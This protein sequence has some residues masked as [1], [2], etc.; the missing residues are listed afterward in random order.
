MV[1]S[2]I[3]ANAALNS[4]ENVSKNEISSTFN[5]AIEQ[6]DIGSDYIEII[7]LTTSNTT[8]KI[9]SDRPNGVEQTDLYENGELLSRGIM[10][11]YGSKYLSI[12]AS[13]GEYEATVMTL[14][15]EIAAENKKLC[16]V[17]LL[18]KYMID[19]L[20][21]YENASFKEV[22][23]LDSFTTK[24]SS[25]KINLYFNEDTGFLSKREYL[26]NG[27]V[28]QRM[29]FETIDKNSKFAQ[30]L[31]KQNSPVEGTDI[32]LDNIET[33]YINEGKDVPLDEAR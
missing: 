7:T 14:D 1:S 17:S 9:Y 29:E 5:K 18:E 6:A 33:T 16:Q 12:G 19:D 21:D 13:N 30:S 23:L 10:Y 2:S 27:E 3:I 31:F 15:P 28:F 22:Q 32:N 8:L 26:K 4:D 24:Y 11:D 20:K 25:D